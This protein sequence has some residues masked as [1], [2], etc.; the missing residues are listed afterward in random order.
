MR[1]TSGRDAAR[2][3][4]AAKWRGS[5]ASPP[6]SFSP[7]SSRKARSS[8]TLSG[9]GP[10]WT[11]KSAGSRWRSRNFAAETLAATMLSSMIRCATVRAAGSRR[12]TPAVRSEH[13]P[14]L[15]H[16]EVD[17]APIFAR[18]AQRNVRVA[19][20]LQH[21][22]RRS[23]PLA[24]TRLAL[25][26]RPGHLGIGQAGLRTDHAFEEPRTVHPTRAGHDH[27]ATEAEPVFVRPE[28]AQPVRDRFGQHGDDPV[29]EVDGV[30]AQPRFPRPAPSRDGRQADT[31]A[32]ATMSRHPLA[33]RSQY[34][35][36]SKSRASSPSMV[37]NPRPRRSSRPSTSDS[38]T[39]EGSAAASRSTTSGHAAGS[40]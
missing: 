7:N 22:R 12:T 25:F 5:G 36:S 27:L 30:P 8:F 14:G 24:R 37:T 33:V 2:S 38:S 19:Q 40:S 17:R 34:T 32:I 15:G 16:V 39:S 29:R 6:P 3:M 1:W 13:H 9:G 28:R 26:E 31:S 4:T 10:S 20:R 35:A 18:T 11:R 21:R 23:E